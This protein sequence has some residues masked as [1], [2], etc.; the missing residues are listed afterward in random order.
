MKSLVARWAVVLEINRSVLV[1]VRNTIQIHE[2]LKEF[3]AL[4][5]R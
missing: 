5:D 4:R 3:L 2:F 1:L